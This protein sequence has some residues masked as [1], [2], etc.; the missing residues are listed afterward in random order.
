MCDQTQ[1]LSHNM[2]CT[3][4]TNE[5]MKQAALKAHDIADELNTMFREESLITLMREKRVQFCY[6]PSVINGSLGEDY[7]KGTTE[8]AHGGAL[9]QL[10]VMLDKDEPSS[11]I[12]TFGAGIFG[13]VWFDVNLTG[14]H[15]KFKRTKM[16]RVTPIKKNDN[17][18]IML[19]NTFDEKW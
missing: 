3:S 1:D 17:W 12:P 6:H 19:D 11:P 15:G 7:K 16:V 9:L 14:G 5:Q 2:S 4:V 13:S 18:L 10:C 8:W